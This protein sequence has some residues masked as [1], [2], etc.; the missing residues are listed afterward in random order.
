MWIMFKLY[1]SILHLIKA[2]C[3]NCKGLFKINK[4]PFTIVK[5]IKFSYN[6]KSKQEFIIRGECYGTSAKT[7]GERSDHSI[8]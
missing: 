4:H 5:S 8:G 1:C 3:S 2:F 7:R 6:I